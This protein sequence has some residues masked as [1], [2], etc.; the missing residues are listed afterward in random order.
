M[1]FT[2][3]MCNRQQNAGQ[4]RIAIRDPSNPTGWNHFCVVCAQTEQEEGAQPVRQGRWDSDGTVSRVV[5][6]PAEVGG[7][8]T[9]AQRSSAGSFSSGRGDELAS[10]AAAAAAA[11]G[12]ACC[13]AGGM[14]GEEGGGHG[15]EEGA[16]EEE[17]EEVDEGFANCW[18]NDPLQ[19]AVSNQLKAVHR[20]LPSISADGRLVPSNNA[21]AGAPAA[22][23]GKGKGKSPAWKGKGMSPKEIAAAFRER[24]PQAPICRPV[25]NVET[26][27]IAAM[28]PTP[29]IRKAATMANGRIDEERMRELLREAAMAV[30][31]TIN[32]VVLAFVH[33]VVFF[34]QLVKDPRFRV[35]VTAVCLNITGV[36][37]LIC[38]LCSVGLPPPPIVR[39]NRTQEKRKNMAGCEPQV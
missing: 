11:G 15:E 4:E 31:A 2:C 32:V 18:S 30:F 16:D 14:V 1:M 27:A 29:A 21:A 25:D 22:L 39:N 35:S 17:E 26:R 33:E 3:H 28:K 12:A 6:H 23:K 9:S 24:F 5:R 34:E 38:V 37:N 10:A 19:V 7:G 36:Y 20:H 8:G 13:D